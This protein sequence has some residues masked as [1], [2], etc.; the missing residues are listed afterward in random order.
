MNL[1][2]LLVERS[3]QDHATDIPDFVQYRF[4]K[5]RPTNGPQKL[6]M[7][8]P[9]AVVLTSCLRLKSS[10]SVLTAVTASP[11]ASGLGGTSS[12]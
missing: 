12:V 9:L 4:K 1:L 6:P 11:I 7:A 8:A 10:L 5:N 3:L 2:V